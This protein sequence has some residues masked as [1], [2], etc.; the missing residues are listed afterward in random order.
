MAE[1]GKIP[2]TVQRGFRRSFVAG[3]RTANLTFFSGRGT[4]SGGLGTEVGTRRG[5]LQGGGTAGVTGEAEMTGFSL[6]K[7]TE[8]DLSPI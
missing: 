8:S 2:C 1:I 7:D 3:T 4:G 6:S 5:R